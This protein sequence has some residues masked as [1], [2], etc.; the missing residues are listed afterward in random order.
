[1]ML[2]ILIVD[3]VKA[4][5]VSIPSIGS[6]AFL[7]IEKIVEYTR[8]GKYVSIPSIGSMAFLYRHFR[9][10]LVERLHRVS[11]P[12]IGSMAFLSKLERLWK[13]SP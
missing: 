9:H 2:K 13:A 12:S 6:M 4:Q 5:M 8:S 1:M 10:E 7:Y 11:I 3:I